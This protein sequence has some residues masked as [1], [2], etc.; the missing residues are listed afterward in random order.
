[1][2]NEDRNTVVYGPWPG[3][4]PYEDTEELVLHTREL[5][6]DIQ[7][8]ELDRKEKEEIRLP[9]WMVFVILFLLM[10]FVGVFIV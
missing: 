4:L 6:R 10:V 3:A 5:L 8:Q 1:M 7:Q 2:T 9:A